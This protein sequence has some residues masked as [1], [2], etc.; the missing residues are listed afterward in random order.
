MKSRN[1]PQR[2]HGPDSRRIEGRSKNDPAVPGDEPWHETKVLK[3]LWPPQPGTL[4][5]RDRFGGSLVCVRYRHD[6]RSAHRYTTV[7]LLVD[8]APRPRRAKPPQGVGTEAGSGSSRH[9]AAHCSR[10]GAE[11]DP[12]AEVWRLTLTM[13][14]K[15]GITGA[16]R[17]TEKR[18]GMV[19][20]RRSVL[21]S[22][23]T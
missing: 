7:E 18:V 4:Q 9:F 23:T 20:G 8:H 1:S 13:A 21:G 19:T 3:T 16:I 14:R 6:A 5:W 22:K 15:L 12:E 10:V 11:W 17:R 2:Q